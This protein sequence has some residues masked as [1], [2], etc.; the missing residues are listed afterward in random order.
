MSH[1]DQEKERPHLLLYI[2]L[3]HHLGTND[4]AISHSSVQD[5]T[6]T[7]KTRKVAFVMLIHR[8]SLYHTIFPSQ[9]LCNLDKVVQFIKVVKHFS[10]LAKFL[11]MQMMN[12]IGW[13]DMMNLFVVSLQNDLSE[14]FGALFN[15]MHLSNNASVAVI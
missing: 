2:T 5:L 9:F 10:Y 1:C 14:I 8:I 12:M 15:T 7:L 4:D 13:T 11:C 3:I 6:P